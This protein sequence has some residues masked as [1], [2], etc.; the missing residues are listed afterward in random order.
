MKHLA[1]VVVFATM[2]VLG[3]VPKAWAGE[4]EACSNA[5]LH[6]SFGYTSTGTLLESFVPPPFAGPFAEVGRQTFDGKGNTDA[7]ATLSA[8]GNTMNVTITGTYKV[9]PD[10]T[11]S[12]TLYTVQFAA[13]SHADFVIDDD[14]AELRLIF[15]DS[16]VIES[17]VYR[18]QFRGSRKDGDLAD[19]GITQSWRAV[20]AGFLPSLPTLAPARLIYLDVLSAMRKL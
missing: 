7:T 1:T 16:G 10:C 15:T 19:V 12:M 20:R 14:G 2:F 17:R 6:G 3:I 11:G 4:D 5:T 9:N 8:N 13:Y 18:K